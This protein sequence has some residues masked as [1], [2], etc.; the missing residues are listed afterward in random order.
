MLKSYKQVVEV[1]SHD[2]YGAKA[3]GP[4][5]LIQ[6]LRVLGQSQCDED[7]SHIPPLKSP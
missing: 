4:L 7:S 5:G 6:S 3:L 2:V 1:K